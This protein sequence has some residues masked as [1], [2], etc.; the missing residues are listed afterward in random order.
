G[1]VP[2][3]FAAFAGAGLLARR[4]LG[5][6]AARLG[7]SR[8]RWWHVALALAAAGAFFALG[9]GLDYLGQKLT[10]GT[11]REVSSA[12]NRIFGQWTSDPA[13]VIT[14]ALAA[15]ICEEALFR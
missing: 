2:F 4:D 11:A 8:P 14:I 12:T 7:Y 3:L 10:P 15:G 1:E 9:V 5:Q 13:G 6:T